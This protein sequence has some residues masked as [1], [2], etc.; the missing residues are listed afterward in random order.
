MCWSQRSKSTLWTGGWGFAPLCHSLVI[1]GRSLNLSDLFHVANYFCLS[2][3]SDTGLLSLIFW[4][5]LEI[6][7]WKY[8]FSDKLC[9]F[10]NNYITN[11]CICGRNH[12]QYLASKPYS[13]CSMLLKIITFSNNAY[14]QFVKEY[15]EDYMSL[16]TWT[17]ARFKKEYFLSAVP[18]SP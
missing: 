15:F 16:N 10:W 9:K 14:L 5:E 3:R 6:L 13:C 12:L 4:R 11:R 1:S 18:Q 8:Q 2:H 7:S 17:N